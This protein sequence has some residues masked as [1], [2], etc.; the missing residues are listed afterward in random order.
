M[1]FRF[2]AAFL[3]SFLFSITFG[4]FYTQW[5]KKNNFSQPLKKEVVENVYSPN[6]EENPSSQTQDDG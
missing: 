1:I 6:D 2:L 5:L 4:K 3:L